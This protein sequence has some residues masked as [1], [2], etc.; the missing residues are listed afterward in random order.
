MPEIPGFG[1]L[2]QNLEPGQACLERQR[3]MRSRKE[4]QARKRNALSYQTG[5]LTLHLLR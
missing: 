1:R 4:R 3:K 2:R 5:A